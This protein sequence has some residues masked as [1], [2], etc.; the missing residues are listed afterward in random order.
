MSMGVSPR[1]FHGGFSGQPWHHDPGPGGPEGLGQGAHLLER[2]PREGVFGELS[3]PSYYALSL[4]GP[5]RAGESLRRRG[6]PGPHFAPP[7]RRR[8]R[9]HPRG[10]VPRAGVRWA[11]SPAPDLVG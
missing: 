7:R 11:P 4:A 2:E 1:S 6:G 3:P 10:A 9:L 5:R 8:G